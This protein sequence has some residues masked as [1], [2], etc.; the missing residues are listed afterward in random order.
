MSKQFSPLTGFSKHESD[1]KII[2]NKENKKPLTLNGNFYQIIDDS[3]KKRYIHKDKIEALLSKVA[4]KEEKAAKKE[5]KKPEG[6][7]LKALYK[8]LGKEADVIRNGG[9]KKEI[10]ASEGKKSS[11]RPALELTKE[12]KSKIDIILGMECKKQEKSYRLHLLGLNLKQIATLI[13]AKSGVIN[14]GAR[15]NDINMYL[16]DKELAATIK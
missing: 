11:R 16:R 9:P 15:S 10:K 13:P 6:K 3:K 12:I 1:G 2:R 14:I 4:P 5:D 8:D 7:A